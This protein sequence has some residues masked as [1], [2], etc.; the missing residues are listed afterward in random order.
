MQAIGYLFGLFGPET[1]DTA[2][3]EVKCDKPSYSY[4]GE[5]VEINPRMYQIDKAAIVTLSHSKQEYIQKQSEWAGV[6]W[7]CFAISIAAGSG[8]INYCI[9][10]ENPS[11]NLCMI[12]GVVG[13]AFVI[14]GLYSM[15]TSWEEQSKWT[16]PIPNLASIRDFQETNA[17]CRFN[18]VKNNPSYFH[19]NEIGNIH[20]TTMSNKRTGSWKDVYNA[21]ITRADVEFLEYHSAKIV[22]SGHNEVSHLSQSKLSEISNLHSVLQ[23]RVN[24][25]QIENRNELE[26]HH[27]ELKALTNNEK[28]Y[29]NV[30]G[31]VTGTLAFGGGVV[32]SGEFETAKANLEKERRE[33]TDIANKLP[34]HERSAKLDEINK[35]YQRDLNDLNGK[36]QVS[37]IGTGIFAGVLSNAGQSLVSSSFAG[38]INAKK[39]IIKEIEERHAADL[40]LK[41]TKP[42]SQLLDMYFNTV[43]KE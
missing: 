23:Q 19:S 43:L 11:D 15:Y 17:C 30:V 9:K 14:N 8:S 31:D 22:D 1:S 4:R 27:S 13:T 29:K 3:V 35:K 40:N 42:A 12:V 32:L 38:G 21:P 28:Y 7:G 18:Q 36:A 5:I 24:V 34:V 41:M 33:N 16:F 2:K 10:N 37:S 39:Q 20:W 25:I 6:K 26:A